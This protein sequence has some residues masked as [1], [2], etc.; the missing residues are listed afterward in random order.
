MVLP[1]AVDA[2]IFARIAL[3]HESGLLQKPD[4]SGIARDAGGFEAVQPQL[5]KAKGTMARTAAVM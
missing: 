5:A 1:D 3:S 4:R 2:Q